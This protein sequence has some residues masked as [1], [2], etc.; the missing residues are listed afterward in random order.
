MPRQ[1]SASGGKF[2]PNV[3]PGDVNPP[4]IFEPSADLAGT[5]N[6]WAILSG[7][8]NWGGAVCSISFDGTNYTY[9]GTVTAAALQG[10]L[11]ATL[12]SHADPDTTN[13]LSIDLTQSVGI[14]PTAATHADADAFR[15]L[16]AV[17]PAIGVSNQISSGP[18]L[19]CY[20]A[21]SATGTYTSNLTYLRR[22]L[23]GTAPASHGI[24]SLFVRL[25]R[26]QA[27]EWASSILEFDLDPQYIGQ[28][29]YLKC[30]S[31][32]V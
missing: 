22:G 3:D 14:L 15:T 11:T 18:E 8:V 32:N 12:A 21:V 2:D 17:I 31:F 20:G 10:T 30:Q 23:F 6:I 29:I 1:V 28:T 16:A 13:T 27:G 19:I 5:G 26:E 9:F 4:G 24:G 25:Q 7:G